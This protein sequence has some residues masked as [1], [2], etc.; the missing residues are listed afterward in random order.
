MA[1]T[2]SEKCD[3]A[4]EKGSVIG[5]FSA[6][7]VE[8]R[9]LAFTRNPLDFTRTERKTGGQKRATRFCSIPREAG[10]VAVALSFNLTFV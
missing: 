5:Q 3:S 6:E 8:L 4:R 10:D 9:S 1:V 2:P 7:I